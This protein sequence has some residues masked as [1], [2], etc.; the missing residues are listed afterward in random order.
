MTSPNTTVA[1]G[2]VTLDGADEYGNP[3][4]TVTWRQVDGIWWPGGSREAVNG[5]D[6]VTWHDTICLPTGTPV[7]STDVIIPVVTLDAS[8][9]V[10]YTADGTTPAGDLYQVDGQPTPWPA[11]SAGWQHDYSVVVNLTRVT[12]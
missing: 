7:Q 2:T 10:V 6:Q 12:G 11:N 9:A 8:G 1:I 4:R 3:A 5:Q